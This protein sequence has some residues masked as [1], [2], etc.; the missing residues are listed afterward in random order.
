MSTIFIILVLVFY[1]L[2]SVIA[3]TRKV[4]H[5][6]AIILI[7][8]IFGW[9]ILGWIAALIWAI[10]E[11][12]RGDMQ[13]PKIHGRRETWLGYSEPRAPE[14]PERVTVHSDGASYSLES[15]YMVRLNQITPSVILTL[16]ALF[17][18]ACS[19]IE[20][21]KP[22]NDQ[23]FLLSPNNLVVNHRGCGE[24]RQSTFRAWLNRGEPNEQEITQAFSYANDTWV[25]ITIPLPL[26]WNN[27]TAYADADTGL[28]C[29]ERRWDNQK[30]GVMQQFPRPLKIMPLGDSITRGCCPKG[31]NCDIGYRYLL[32]TKLVKDGYNVDIVGSQQHPSLDPS[33]KC[34]PKD[35]D[36]DHEGYYGETTQGLMQ[37]VTTDFLKQHS[38]DIVL[39]HIGTND[40]K[41]AAS[42]DIDGFVEN[43]RTILERIFIYSFTSSNRGITVVFVALIINQK[44]SNPLVSEYNEKLRDMVREQGYHTIV[45]NMETGAGLDYQADIMDDH[46]HPNASGYTKM[47]DLWYRTLVSF[48]GP[49]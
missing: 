4:Q 33:L 41:E 13:P 17:F 6:S 1:L 9:T 10:V 42:R 18:T 15:R 38:P 16:L 22:S 39:L 26:G 2:P 24:V 27:F 14:T 32:I 20:I 36:R 48:L 45:V 3:T 31:R 19:S 35:F 49:P 21:R 5:D 23:Q 44:P 37:I 8:V 40:L 29:F 30:M 11:Q 47:A 25:S 7:N 28:F 43:V 34:T 46:L 12:P